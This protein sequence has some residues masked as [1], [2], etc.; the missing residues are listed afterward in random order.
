MP[1]EILTKLGT[2]IIFGHAADH[3]P[4]TANNLG[5]DT[6]EID[7]TSLG[8]GSYRQSAKADFGG[9]TALWAEW[10]AVTAAIEPVSAPTAGTSIDFWMGF[11]EAT[12]TTGN[13]AGLTGS[14]AVYNGYD[15]AAADATEAVKQLTYVG[16]LVLAA[17]PDVQVAHLG[18]VRVTARYGMLVVYNGGNV[19]L[20]ADGDEQSIRFTPLIPEVQ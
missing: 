13:P 12:S 6:H 20:A 7:L 5:A 3:N 9:G 19:A 10:W 14:D 2:P 1:N 17:D 18:L 8:A 16:S 4:A 11:S 15:A